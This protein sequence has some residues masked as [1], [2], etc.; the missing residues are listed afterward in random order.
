MIRAARRIIFVADHAK[1]KHVATARIADVSQVDVLITD[2][3]AA[4]D[5]VR[6][7]RQTK[8]QVIIA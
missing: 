2:S 8:L 4:P 5:V 1:L 6:E 7:L 3:G